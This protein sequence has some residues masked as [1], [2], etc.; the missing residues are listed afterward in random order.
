MAAYE[1]LLCPGCGSYKTPDRL[2]LSA[3]GAF[4][5][6]TAAPNELCLRTDTIGGRGRLS[7]AKD[8]APLHFAL[9]MRDMLKYRL[10]Q[11]EAELRAAG[12]ELED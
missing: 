4:D 9:G 10:A 11:V 7:V 8:A 6:L 12:V 5:P 1:R 3:K 2:G